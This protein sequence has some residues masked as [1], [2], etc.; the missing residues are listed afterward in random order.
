MDRSQRRMM[1]LV[2][3]LA[4]LGT[5]VAAAQSAT[6][7]VAGRAAPDFA[8]PAATQAGVLPHQIRLSELRG[9]TVVLAFFY[10]ARTKG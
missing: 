10:K 2:S 8:L 4:L 3:A 1:A 9:N 6:P 7:L 5:G